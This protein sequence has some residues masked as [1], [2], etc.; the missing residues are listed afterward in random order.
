[1]QLR[2]MAVM[3]LALGACLVDSQD[4]CRPELCPVDTLHIACRNRGDFSRS[5]PAD[6]T[7]LDIDE[8]ARKQ[9]VDAHNTLRQKWASGGGTVRRAAC[10][11]ATISWDPEL[12]RLAELNARQCLLEHD[13]CHNTHKYRQ[14]GQNLYMAGF[15]GIIPSAV[16]RIL[17]RATDDWAAEGNDITAEQLQAFHLSGPD[18]THF[19]V[20]ANEANVAVGCAVTRFKRQGFHH[21]LVACNYATGNTLRKPVYSACSA[22]GGACQTKANPQYSALCSKEEPLQF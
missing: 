7:R 5:C 14:S 11:M 12:A 17:K 2:C 9:L 16:E 6:A 18:V 10:R 22:A 13:K 20:M 1:M 8:A 3:C 21:F 19:A 4:Y 15:A